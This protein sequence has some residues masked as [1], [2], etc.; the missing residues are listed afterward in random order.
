MISLMLMALACLLLGMGMPTVPAHMI[1]LLVIGP[2]L[3]KLGVPIIHTHMFVLYFGVLSAVSHRRPCR[4]AYCGGRR[5][6]HSC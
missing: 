2:A 6:A 1:I 5:G 4:G 3:Q